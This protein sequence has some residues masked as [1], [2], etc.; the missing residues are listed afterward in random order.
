MNHLVIYDEIHYINDKNRGKV[1][2]ES[3]IQIPKTVQMIG[4]SATINNPQKLCNLLHNSNGKIHIYAYMIKE[5][6]HSNITVLSLQLIQLSRTHR[7]KNKNY[8][9][10]L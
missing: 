9:M 4:L 6:Y 10:I 5:L 7:K 8:S 3:I 1:W 2:E